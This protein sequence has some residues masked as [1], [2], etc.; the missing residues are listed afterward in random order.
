M[1]CPVITSLTQ[2]LTDL[3]VDDPSLN[4]CISKL[5]LRSAIGVQKYGHTLARKDI[6]TIDQPIARFIPA[7]APAFRDSLRNRITIRHLLTM[8]S[9][10]DWP[11]GGGYGSDDDITQRMENSADWVSMVLAQPMD[12]VP[13]T[14]YHYN[15]GAA[16]LLAEVFRG[17]TGVDLQAY[18]QQHL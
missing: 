9:G 16:A 12:A 4:A 15:D 7:H 5:K 11:E 14:T 17:A 8:T 10:I 1:I 6:T 2:R 13:G 18:A 3:D